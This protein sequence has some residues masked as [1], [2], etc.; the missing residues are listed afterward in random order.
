[1]KATL[2]L[3]LAQLYG[4]DDETVASILA[5]E[6]LDELKK[7]VRKEIRAREK[8]IVKIAAKA[9]SEALTSLD[10]VTVNEVIAEIQASR[11]KK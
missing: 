7:V 9:V 11:R 10:K 2:D 5:R 4:Y 8:E 1:M 6:V 3:D